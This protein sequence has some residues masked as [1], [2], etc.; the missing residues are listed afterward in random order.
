MRRIRHARPS[1]TIVIAVLALVA[2]MT[3]TAIAGQSA[4]ISVSKKKV[5][6]IAKNVARKQIDRRFPVGSG[7]LG[8]I[9]T[10]TA[11]V[12]LPPSPPG[13]TFEATASCQPGEKVISGGV[14]TPNQ[15]PFSVADSQKAG[16]GWRARVSA[17][18]GV[19]PGT[20]PQLT[21]EAYCLAR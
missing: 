10:R 12:S 1:P 2:A 4:S 11:H 8:T 5:R 18:A 3:T 19:P 15:E 7:R 6:T 21:V 14:D 20:P 9:N 17:S 16:E 13:T